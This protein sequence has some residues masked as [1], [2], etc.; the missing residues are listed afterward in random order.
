[1]RSYSEGGQISHVGDAPLSHVSSNKV[2]FIFWQTTICTAVYFNCHFPS[3]IRQINRECSVFLGYMSLLYPMSHTSPTN[4]YFPTPSMNETVRLVREKLDKIQSRSGNTDTA[5]ASK[6]AKFRKR[7]ELERCKN[8]PLEELLQRSK[9]SPPE[10][11]L[12]I[13]NLLPQWLVLGGHMS[14]RRPSPSSSAS[15]SSSDTV[16]NEVSSAAPTH[17][18]RRNRQRSRRPRV[19]GAGAS[20]SVVQDCETHA[21]SS[22]RRRPKR[23]IDGD[24]E[25]VCSSSEERIEEAARS[26]LFLAH[27]FWSRSEAEDDGQLA[28]SSDRQKRVRAD[29]NAADRDARRFQCP[30]CD[31]VFLSG[32]GLGG[33]IRIH[34]PT[35][36]ACSIADSPAAAAPPPPPPP[37]SVS[38]FA[39]NH[40]C[41]DLDRPSKRSPSSSS[42][43]A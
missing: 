16:A 23:R 6:R 18:L 26:L 2:C 8:C 22:F 20:S 13:S 25:A 35:S 30:H 33:H 9:N 17:G 1:M 43:E 31:R 7:R 40:G 4:E 10:E 14:S 12:R 29:A 11:L 3:S 37:R 42:E 15:S 19:P 28:A 34:L 36:A 32:Q 5:S 38:S 41:T 39:S 24:A 21:E 27:A